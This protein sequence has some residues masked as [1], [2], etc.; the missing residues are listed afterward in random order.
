[1]KSSKTNTTLPNFKKKN[2]KMGKFFILFVFFAFFASIIMLSNVFATFLNVKNIGIFANN[3]NSNAINLYCVAYGEYESE[4]SATV[5]ADYLKQKGGAGFI[6]KLDN[7]YTILLSAY[8]DENVCKKVFNNNKDNFDKL[9]TQKITLS[10]TNYKYNKVN[11]DV[12]PL[13]EI[14]DVKL[15]VFKTLCE[16]SNS[17]DSGQMLSSEVYNKLFNLSY[18]VNSK[19]ENFKNSSSLT[20]LSNYNQLI[21]NAQN[22]YSK[23]NNFILS[24]PKAQL[25]S[26]LK[27]CAIDI[28]LLQ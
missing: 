8:L 6:Y 19:I 25:S 28:I 27:Y 9:N 18:S 17:F 14:I 15:N 4:K 24:T 23:L 7:C 12:K 20:T 21:L 11:T 26:S 10:K 13:K 16:I 1:M 22:V 2:K 5:Q 3:V